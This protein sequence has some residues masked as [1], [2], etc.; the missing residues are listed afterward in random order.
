MLVLGIPYLHVPDTLIFGLAVFHTPDTLMYGVTSFHTPET[1]IHSFVAGAAVEGFRM[2]KKLTV[3][4]Q[5]DIQA[6][7]HCGQESDCQDQALSC[8]REMDMSIPTR[9][10]TRTW[11]RIYLHKKQRS[12]AS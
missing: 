4:P 9:H 11:Q 6:R 7:R 3:D 12:T 2:V 10:P 8:H 1:L 5:V